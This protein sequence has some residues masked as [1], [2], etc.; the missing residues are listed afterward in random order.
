MFRNSWEETEHEC[1][2]WSVLR[3]KWR[4]YC[5]DSELH[6]GGY[7]EYIDVHA[8]V[9]EAWKYVGSGNEIV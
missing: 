6:P 3:E 2:S 9:M 1:V 8:N 5:F 7:K 4:S